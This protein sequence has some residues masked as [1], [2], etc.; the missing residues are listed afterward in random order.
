MFP[1]LLFFV[2]I[3]ACGLV[4]A[5][6]PGKSLGPRSYM[7]DAEEAHKKAYQVISEK[8]A[9]RQAILNRILFVALI[10]VILLIVWIFGGFSG[11]IGHQ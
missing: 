2:I 9:R 6:G 7:R 10:T 3:I 1:Y 11:F 8:T 5:V 4:N